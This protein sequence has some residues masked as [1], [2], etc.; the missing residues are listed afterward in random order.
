MQLHKLPKTTTRPQKRVGRGYGSGRGG[1]TSGRGQKG[2]NTRGRS[3]IWFEGGQLPLIRRTPFVKGKLRN[4]SLKPKPVIVKLE[5]LNAF[6]EGA[7]V[8]LDSLIS[9]LKLPKN[10]K[11]LGVKILSQ[12]ELTKKLDIQVPMSASV[13]KA[14]EKFSAP[15]VTRRTPQTKKTTAKDK[16]TK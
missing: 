16:K 4:P 14:L 2:Q 12:G 13:K 6:K 10:A 7:T 15:E 8:T 5:A 1:H 11:K 9:T 3:A